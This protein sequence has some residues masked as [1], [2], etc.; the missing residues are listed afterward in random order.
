[1]PHVALVAMSGVRIVD[2]G[3]LSLGLTLPGARARSEAIAELPASGL[4][5]LAALSG[6]EWAQSYHAA[7]LVTDELLQEILC[8]RP[9]LVAVSALTAS[10]N[11]AY[12]LSRRLRSEG[13]LTV[14]G[15]LHATAC[16][17]EAL[18]PF[19]AVCIGDGEPVWPRILAD[20]RA[21]CLQPRYQFADWSF[22]ASAIVPRWELLRRRRW[23]GSMR[24]KWNAG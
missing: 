13:V 7:T 6:F 1:M 5:T 22:P 15:G 21:G 23:P 10:V 20:V 19:D 12:D 17:D 4:L 14:L 24:C 16:P 8:H 11:L 3:L 9:T 18:E 2:E